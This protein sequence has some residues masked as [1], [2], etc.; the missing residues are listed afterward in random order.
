M[1]I[2]GL[3][4]TSLIDYPGKIA[5]VVFTYG[6]N[7]RCRFCHNPD[8]VTGRQNEQQNYSVEEVLAFLEKRKG[9]LEGVVITGG[10]PLLHRDLTDF[11]RKIK[12]LNYAIKLDTNGANPKILK[13]L[14]DKGLVDYIAMDIKNSPEKY[15]LTAGIRVNLKDI[16]SSINLIIKSG[17]SYEFRSTILPKLHSKEDFEKMGQ[18]IKGANKFFVQGFRPGV[19]LE[20]SFEKERSL[21]SKELKEIAKIFTKYV[22]KVEIRE[23]L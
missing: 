10:E 8:L 2:S 22:K 14:I 13:E 19:T 15:E 6:C 4:K 20:K 7:F 3:V 5:A 18:M 23:N 21:T 11:I 1:I 12:E 16:D 17:L 9:I